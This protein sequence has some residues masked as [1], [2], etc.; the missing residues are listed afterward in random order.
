M[1]DFD[2]PPLGAEAHEEIALEQHDIHK[3]YWPVLKAM[4]GP[5]A[6]QLLVVKDAPP[7][8]RQ[9]LR[10]FKRLGE[11]TCAL[12]DAESQRYPNAP[13]L[14]AWLLDLTSRIEAMVMTNL[15]E[16]EKG[17]L[18]DIGTPRGSLTYHATWDEMRTSIRALL[19]DRR[20]KFKPKPAARY[21][22]PGGRM[23]F[24]FPSSYEYRVEPPKLQQPTTKTAPI[25][26]TSKLAKRKRLSNTVTSEIAARK[27]EAFLEASPVEKTDF[28]GSVGI[29]PRTLLRFRR[30]GKIK[31]ATLH[32]IAK[33]MGTTIED[34]LKQ[35]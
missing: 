9:P 32:D 18:L 3:R 33:A 25:A 11:Y 22:G 20:E 35:S 21:I 1:E 12:F 14:P 24:S 17:S 4:A 8:P 13:Q 16:I 29:T 27:L 30:T 23:T 34:L 2:R 7:P 26:D 10:L 15:A 28:A 5:T 6:I 19:K 31:R